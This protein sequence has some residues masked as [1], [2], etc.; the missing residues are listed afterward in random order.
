MPCRA[1]CR[2]QSSYPALLTGL[3][4]TMDGR[5]DRRARAGAGAALHRRLASLLPRTRPKRRSVSSQLQCGVFLWRSAA[6]DGPMRRRRSAEPFYRRHV[7][8]SS[9]TLHTLGLSYGRSME[10]GPESDWHTARDGSDAAARTN[11]AARGQTQ[12]QELGIKATTASSCNRPNIHARKMTFVRNMNSDQLIQ[13]YAK[14]PNNINT[15]NC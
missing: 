12:P 3:V 13:N 10:I 14:F 2:Q 9:G 1:N 4:D 6:E 5:G 7:K 15:R 8:M 11:R